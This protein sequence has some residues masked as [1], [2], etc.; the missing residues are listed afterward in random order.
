MSS[1]GFAEPAG[2]HLQ[3]EDK[4]VVELDDETVCAGATACTEVDVNGP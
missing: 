4:D 2:S 1:V 3:A